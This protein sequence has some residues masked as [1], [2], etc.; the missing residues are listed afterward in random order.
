MLFTS[1]ITGASSAE[2]RISLISASCSSSSSASS[3]ASATVLC[4][5]LSFPIRD[6]T[7]AAGATATRQFR[8]VAIC[9]SSRATT[10]AGSAIARISV[11]SSTKPI[12]TALWRRADLT[13]IRFA[14]PMS[15]WKTARSTK[16][17]PYRSATAR[18]TCSESMTP[19]SSRSCS[20]ERPA[21]RDCAT[22]CSICS[23]VA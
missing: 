5:V 23:G 11:A 1:L 3:I 13:E 19:C 17:R 15:T 12:G 9:T 14:A 2:A 20:G 10:L 4:R 18:V 7:S 22:A 16:S 6:S 8:P 21:V